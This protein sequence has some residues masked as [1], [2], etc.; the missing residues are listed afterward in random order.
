MCELHSDLHDVPL[1]IAPDHVSGLPGG[2]THV[3]RV[4]LCYV[5]SALI[6]I[7]VTGSDEALPESC[8]SKFV[9]TLI[10]FDLHIESRDGG[11]RSLPCP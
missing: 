3:T 9:L 8:D 6:I 11:W 5:A 4:I 2:T 1:L 10:Y 7:L